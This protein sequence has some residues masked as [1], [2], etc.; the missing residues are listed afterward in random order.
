MGHPQCQPP[1]SSPPQIFW[2]PLRNLFIPV[3][4]NCWLAKHALE[5]MIVSR[6]PGSC[7]PPGLGGE[8]P[9]TPPAWRGAGHRPSVPQEA[10]VISRSM[11]C[12]SPQKA[13]LRP[14]ISVLTRTDLRLVLQG[15]FSL[16]LCLSPG[17]KWLQGG[18]ARANGPQRPGPR[19]PGP[20]TDPLLSVWPRPLYRAVSR[21][22]DTGSPPGRPSPPSPGPLGSPPS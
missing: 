5:N 9:R 3:F 18:G 16:E 10:R 21:Q 11:L 1:D 8:P 22:P 2:A 4:L 6:G 20:R 12:L 15:R 13:G 7:H 14:S 19:D 17:N